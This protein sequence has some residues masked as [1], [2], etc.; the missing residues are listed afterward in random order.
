MFKKLTP[1]QLHQL[2]KLEEEFRKQ[3]EEEIISRRKEL[4]EQIQQHEKSVKENLCSL[5]AEDNETIRR[6]ESLVSGLM[7]KL[8]PISSLFLE[9]NAPILEK[10]EELEK[11]IFAL[12]ICEKLLVGRPISPKELHDKV[13]AEWENFT[14][15]SYEVQDPRSTDI[16]YDVKKTPEIPSDWTKSYFTEMWNLFVSHRNGDWNEK[17]SLE[18]EISTLKE[19]IQPLK[20]EKDKLEREI[21]DMKNTSHRIR[22]DKEESYWDTIN[23][24]AEHTRF[25]LELRDVE[26][27]VT[28]KYERL[29][30]DLW[31]HPK[32]HLKPTAGFFMDD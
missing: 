6:N 15:D 8:E 20:D 12:K 22:L 17:L 28:Q 4:E 31:A 24:D 29:I 7:E 25:V 18:K 14:A 13:L 19:E 21:Y 11:L 1:L 5:T 30:E 32:K 26:K 9:K 23:T 2:K 10:E 3:K 27:N 16:Y